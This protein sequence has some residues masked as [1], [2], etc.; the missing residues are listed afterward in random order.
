ML[1]LLISIVGII[2]TLLIIIGIHE[3]GHF[4]AARCLGVKVLRFSLGFGKA[5]WRKTDKRGTEYVI[6][7]IPLGGYVKM[8]DE[9]EGPVPDNQ[10]HLSY[11]T[12]PFYKKFII[13]AAGP[14]SNLILA[15]VL[16]WLL[17]IIGFNS[18]APVIGNIIPQSIASQAG[19]KPNQE[20]VS[21]DNKTTTGWMSVIIRI[22][23]HTGETG[24]LPIET[25]SF[26]VS[27]PI[28]PYTLDLQNW[29]MDN[30]KPDPLESL[31]IVPYEPTIPAIIGKV[32]TNSPAAKSQLQIGDKITAID[33]KPIQNWLDML[34]IIEKNPSQ[35]LIFTLDRDA[36]HQV[37]PVT[38]GY[39]RDML[40]KKHGYLGIMPQF[41]LPEGM[42]R[43]VQYGPLTAIS[44]A[45]QNLCDFTFLNLN[46]VGKLLTGKASLKS[47]GGPISIF[48]SAGIALNQG[49]T[50]F[51]SFLAF[52][53]ISIGI[54]NIFPIPG[55]DGGH[56]LF[57]VIEVIIRRPIPQKYL[58]LFYRLGVILLLLLIFQ[59][60]TNDILRLQ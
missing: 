44:H 58:I 45:W 55:L 30:L 18:I 49:I 24:S 22:L 27:S 59:A 19:L 17:F 50:S 5:L 52:L 1:S 26:N 12:Q 57:Q 60:V 10:L 25:K 14:L 43:K 23:S 39:Q 20:I 16:Y 7:A 21:V 3:L 35:Q 8:L 47:L 46:L 13:V 32:E 9:D 53:S 40:L 11:N 28:Y 34:T 37:V 48:Q 56:I 54:I 38:I 41:K 29:H 42:L 4:L 31:G 51:M 15:F 36:K 33:G 6:A 2:L